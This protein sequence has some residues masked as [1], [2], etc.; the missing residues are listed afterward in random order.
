MLTELPAG[1]SRLCYINAPS[2]PVASQP[3]SYSH[4][5]PPSCWGAAPRE[6]QRRQTYT[7]DRMLPRGRDADWGVRLAATML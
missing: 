5:M 1:G 3:I 7:H 2:A 4:A 6:T